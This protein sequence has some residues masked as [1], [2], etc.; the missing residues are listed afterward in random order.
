MDLATWERMKYTRWTTSRNLAFAGL[1]LNRTSF[2]GSLY[3]SA[4]PIGGRSQEGTYKVDARFNRATIIK[5]IRA[6]AELSERVVSVSCD[7][8]MRFVKV[9]RA[10]A[11][12]QDWMAFIYLDPPFWAKAQFL[13][14]RWF[15][16][17]EH[18]ELAEQLKFVKQPWLLSYD[19]APQIV[20]LYAEHKGV[21][22]ANVEL[23]YAGSARACGSEIVVT[24]LDHLPQ[25]TRLYRTNAERAVSRRR[26]SAATPTRVAST[27]NRG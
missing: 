18:E 15:T 8:A 7:D 5:R 16:E 14:S 22:V 1:Y 10:E 2:N 24:N 27:S 11:A 26:P 20:A 4:G 21:Q 12:R 9:T 13:Y 3:R 17:L 23:F 25:H 6:C 19:P